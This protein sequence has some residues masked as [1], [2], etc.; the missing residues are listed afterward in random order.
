MEITLGD[1]DTEFGN[2]SRLNIL[3]AEDDENLRSMLAIVLRREGHRVQE[4]RNGGDLEA[5]L[6]TALVAG[7]SLPRDLFIVADLRMPEMDGLTVIRTLIQRG[8]AAPFIL[9]TAFGS[10]EVHTAATRL[11]AIRVLDK[12]FDFNDLRLAIRNYARARSVA[13]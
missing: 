2:R 12:P 10:P 7:Q 6:A 4:F 9:L 8:L 11:G 3:L 1:D 13:A 5:H